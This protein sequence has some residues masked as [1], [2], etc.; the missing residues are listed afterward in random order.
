MAVVT[1]KKNYYKILGVPESASKGVIK[2]AYRKLAL[3]Y[4]PDR[5]KSPG[6]EEK[7]K[8]I[9]EAYAV[10]SDDEK[11]K[12]YDTLGD[13]GFDHRYT[14]EDIFRGADFDSIFRDMGVS[15]GFG[16][17]FNVF[18]GGQGFEEKQEVIR[19]R[20]LQ[21]EVD[22]T[23]E[24]AA[25]GVEKEIEV[26]RIERCGVCG[27]S[28]A[29]P[30]TSVQTCPKCKGSG[31]LRITN[32]SGSR[33]FVQIVPCSVCKGRGQIIGSPCRNC[34]GK[35][36]VRRVRKITVKIPV[37]VNEGYQLR[38]KGQGEAPLEEGTSGDLYIL[39]HMV[40]HRYFSR[41][42]DNLLYNLNISIP[43][44]ALGAEVT[45]PAIEGKANLRIHSGT[46]PGQIL[47][48]KGR[49][50]PMIGGYGRGDLRVRVNVVVPERLTQRQRALFE[51]LGKELDQNVP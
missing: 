7:F 8:E 51:E 22:V 49:G 25:R 26:P 5:N 1:E 47:R 27:G 37:G 6:A 14:R 41:D 16:D 38:L 29:A 42:G 35:G 34:R 28:G 32:R 15:S 45:I 18:F 46:Q 4:H 3:Q 20:D 50:M 12:Q 40:P 10:L 23:L 13:A 33:T 24:E 2:D 11:R 31:K 9:S 44:A 17:L 36:R 48:V 21:T 43:Q 39:I 19:G 30:G